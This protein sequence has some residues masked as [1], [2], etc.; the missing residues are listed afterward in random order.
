[1]GR[2]RALV[3]AAVLAALAAGCS[4]GV[5]PQPPPEPSRSASPTEAPPSATEESRTRAKE[6]R[7]AAFLD[8]ARVVEQGVVGPEFSLIDVHYTSPTDAAADF[9]NCDMRVRRV[10]STIVATTNDN[11][12]HAAGLAIPET[13]ADLVDYVPL[14]RGA[15]AIKSKNQNRPR[16][17][18]PFVLFPNGRVELLHVARRRSLDKGSNVLETRYGEFFYAIGAG[19]PRM[20]AADLEAR[21]IYSLAGAPPSTFWGLVSVRDDR[22][23]SARGYRRSIGDGV[24]RQVE[25]D[26]DG[27]TWSQGD[28][29]LPLGN[30]PISRY[31]G[32]FSHAVG[33][34]DLQAIAMADA[35]PDLPLLVWEL[36]QTDDGKAFRRV[37]LPRDR[38][39][40][41]GMAYASDGALLLA[42]VEEPVTTCGFVGPCNRAGRIWRLPP[43]R[44][45]TW[46]LPDAPRLFGSH[47]SMELSQSAGG[48]IVAR[49]GH[50]TIAVSADGYEWTEAEPGR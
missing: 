16:S 35:L 32:T 7:L 25:S 19:K 18:P 17:Y 39:P 50:Q 6:A 11:W 3:T 48:V 23:V 40:F 46:L 24:W 4:S 37:P 49:T 26:D 33:P 28:V 30:K 38:M 21:E 5:E 15:V 8:R 43:G 41:A 29:R 13:L 10:C 47:G 9:R 27:R 12:A 20:W 42:E 34:G 14:G 44:S 45:R 22:V 2:N 31:A 1:M 36:W